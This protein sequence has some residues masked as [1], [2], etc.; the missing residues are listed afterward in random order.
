MNFFKD[1]LLV[2]KQAF[3]ESLKNLKRN[4][5]FILMPIFYGVLYQV[6]ILAFTNYIAP[7]LG[8]LS[9]FVMPLMISLIL[10]SYYSMLS[11]LIFYNRIS[12]KN[13]EGTFTAYFSSIYSVYFI[14]ILVSWLKTLLL[15]NFIFIL[16]ISIVMLILF[17]PIAES[18]YIGGE[19]YQGAFIHSFN[20]MKE[21]MS[22]WIL[23]FLLYLILIRLLTFDSFGPLE[24]ILSSSLVD[25]IL[26]NFNLIFILNKGTLFTIIAMVLT[27]IYAVFRGNLF[28]ILNNSTRRKRQFMGEFNDF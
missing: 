23:P 21:N 3:N 16:I 2:Y 4:P 11:D 15:N 28:K 5:I 9:G 6:A 25:I 12:F 24:F 1:L 17:N 14:F 10:S 8:V 18:I 7:L 26:G 20:F 27:G 22:L 13:F 19:Q